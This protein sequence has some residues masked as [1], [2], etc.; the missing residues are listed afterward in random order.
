MKRIVTLIVLLSLYCCSFSQQ[1][2]TI[3]G[4]EFLYKGKPFFL[5]GTNTPWDNWNDFGGNYNPQFWEDE[6]AKL[7][8]SGI[9]SSRV[10]ISCDAEGQP[11]VDREGFTQPATQ[12]FWENL[13]DMMT[14]AEKHHIFIIATIS[15][16][17][18]LDSAKNASENWLT[19]LGC[20]QK[21]QQ[22]CDV[23]LKPLLER[24]KNNPYFFAIDI[25]NEPEWTHEHK[26]FGGLEWDYMQM[27]VGMCAATIHSV[28]SPILAT[29]GSA[30]VKWSSEKFEGN[31]WSD[32]ALQEVTM[33]PLAYMD[34]WQIHYYEW[35][36]QFSNP[37]H[38]TPEYWGLQDKPCIIG[39][40]PGNNKIYGFPISY[41]EIYKLPY[42]LGYSGVFPWTSNGAGVGDFGTLKTF[43]P[44][45][46]SF[47][48]SLK[49]KK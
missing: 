41:E 5:I 31:K 48:K 4:N 39:E 13:D 2:V 47:S 42:Q 37:F 30:A 46:K 40:T 15:S 33:D 14:K 43:G 44:G 16:F 32:K 21:I 36:N 17:D 35:T 25:C 49:N 8:T 3:Q 34:F 23:F 22:Y 19:M 18:N 29:V 9:N 26:R 1:R 24:Y 12:Q 6:F 27:F 45:A 28:E 11:T 38:N 10:W 7:E 20:T